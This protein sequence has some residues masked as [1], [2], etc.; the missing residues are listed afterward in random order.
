MQEDME[1]STAQLPTML[2]QQVQEDTMAVRP[3][4]TCEGKKEQHNA[5]PKRKELGTKMPKAK[6]CRS[7]GRP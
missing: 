6:R 2:E 1:E 7:E 3:E 5:L 4:N